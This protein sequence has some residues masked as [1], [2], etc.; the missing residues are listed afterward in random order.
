MKQKIEIKR[1]KK[2]QS[3]SN[4]RAENIKVGRAELIKNNVYQLEGNKI[5]IRNVS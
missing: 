5:L 3:L 1:R 2:Y 4:G